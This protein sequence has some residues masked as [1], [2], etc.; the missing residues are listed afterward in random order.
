MAA[1]TAAKRR[2]AMLLSL[3]FRGTA[4]PQATHDSAQRAALVWLYAGIP[5]ASP[6]DGSGNFLTLINVGGA[7]G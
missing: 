6:A 7:R 1:D 2:S 3:P 5:G 4:Y